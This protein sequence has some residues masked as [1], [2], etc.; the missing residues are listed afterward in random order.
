[1]AIGGRG[2]VWWW[3]IWAVCGVGDAGWDNGTAIDVLGELLLG[4]KAA[5]I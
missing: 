4:G 3:L 1:M 2:R 5:L